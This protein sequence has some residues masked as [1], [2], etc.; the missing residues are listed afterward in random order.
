MGNVGTR[1]LSSPIFSAHPARIV[2]AVDATLDLNRHRLRTI[3][4]KGLAPKRDAN[5]NA[6]RKRG[7]RKAPRGNTQRTGIKYVLCPPRWLLQVRHEPRSLASLHQ[8]REVGKRPDTRKT[9]CKNRILKNFAS[10]LAR[11]TMNEGLIVDARA[12]QVTLIVE[13]PLRSSNGALNGSLTFS[14]QG[15]GERWWS[16]RP[17]YFSPGSR[18]PATRAPPSEA[19]GSLYDYHLRLMR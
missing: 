10:S 12:E 6:S 15:L 13:F 2:V 19:R 9:A 5:E 18:K 8:H 17:G 11:L 3:A 14:N 4:I 16:A 7:R 1:L